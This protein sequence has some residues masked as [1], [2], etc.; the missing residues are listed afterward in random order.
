MSFKPQAISPKPNS[1]QPWR[2]ALNQPSPKQVF[3]TL[4]ASRH[5]PLQG[6]GTAAAAVVRLGSPLAQYA[7][8][9]DYA[10]RRG[11]RGGYSREPPVYPGSRRPPCPPFPLSLACALVRL[12]TR[13]RASWAGCSLLGVLIGRLTD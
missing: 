2:L 9:D 3:S 12:A 5:R 6:A 11:S 10:D 4:L 13:W 7:A 8:C 1:A